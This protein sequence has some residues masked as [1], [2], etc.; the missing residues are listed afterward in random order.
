MASVTMKPE[1]QSLF[2]KLNIYTDMY[3]NLKYIIYGYFEDIIS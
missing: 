3:I 2:C 1:N